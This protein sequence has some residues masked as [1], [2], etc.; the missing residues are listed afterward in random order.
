LKFVASALLFA[1]AFLQA[2]AVPAQSASPLDRAVAEL[3][4]G[5]REEAKRHLRAA[6]AEDADLKLSKEAYSAE[7]I[8]LLA[9]VG[10]EKSP[11]KGSGVA[12]PILLAGG[13]AVAAGGAVALASGSKKNGAPTVSGIRVEPDEVPLVFT[14]IVRVSADAADPEGDPLTYEWSFGNGEGTGSGPSVTHIFQGAAGPRT[15][16]L[17]VRDAKSSAT[18]RREIQVQNVTGLWAGRYGNESFTLQLSEDAGGS[19]RGMYESARES[20]EVVGRRSE[21]RKLE[22]FVLVLN[23]LTFTGTLDSTTRSF[24]GLATRLSPGPDLPTNVPAQMTR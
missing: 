13:G 15:I 14:S 6:L 17:T 10:G 21:G 8:A 23:R 3:R 9:E 19:I 16:E 24:Q 22:V 7:L 5:H 2:A 11:K 20:S 1:F 18:A 4:S 12:L